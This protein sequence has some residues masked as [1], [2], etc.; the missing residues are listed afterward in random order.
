MK[1]GMIGGGNMGASIIAGI[2]KEHEV[3]LV[4]VNR[5]KAARLRR[6]YRVCVADLVETV[7]RCP[8]I[9]LAVKPQQMDQVLSQ[10]KS[11]LLKTKKVLVVSIAAG[12]TTRYIERALGPRVPVIRVMP[13]LPAQIGEGVS[14]LAAGR[15]VTAAHRKIARTVMAGVGSVVDVAEREMDAVTAVSGSGPAYVFFFIE[16]LIKA[17]RAA[18]LSAPLAR[19]LVYETV[20]GSVHQLAAADDAPEGLRI[21]VT[22]KG[23]TTEA[24]IAVLVKARMGGM[25]SEAVKAAKVRSRELA[26]G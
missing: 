22:S 16:C 23:G 19:K 24:A 5:A 4:E 10:L 2:A 3:W 7:A 13:N 6:R 21:K 8:V 9:V 20:L 1:I 11:C 17:A 15:F 12:V 18:G 26:R 25:I 14:A